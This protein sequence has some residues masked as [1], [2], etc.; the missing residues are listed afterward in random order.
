MLYYCDITVQCGEH[1]H[2]VYPLNTEAGISKTISL[3]PH[4]QNSQ[5]AIILPLLLPVCFYSY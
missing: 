2:L 4:F 1:M 5:E 3:N